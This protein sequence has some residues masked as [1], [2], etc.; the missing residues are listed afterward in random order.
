MSRQT[1]LLVLLLAVIIVSILAVAVSVWIRRSSGSYSPEITVSPDSGAPGVLITVRGEGWKPGEE[2]RIAV[3]TPHDVPSTD[4]VHTST[5]VDSQGRFS[6]YFVFQA[7]QRWSDLAQVWVIAQSSES[8]RQANAWFRLER[9]PVTP[10]P[11]LTASVLTTPSVVGPSTV[12]PVV[13]TTA[14]LSAVST[15]TPTRLVLTAVAQ[16]VDHPRGV[17]IVESQVPDIRQ[18]L[19]T[20]DTRFQYIDGTM[21]DLSQVRAQDRIELLGYRGADGE[22]VAE[23]ITLLREPP[24]F[25]TPSPEPTITV[26]PAP[27]TTQLPSNP[28]HGEYYAN[29]S[30]G[31][32]PSFVREES[33][34]NFDWGSGAPVAGFP[35]NH[36]SA[37]WTATWRLERGAYT[38]HVLADDGARLWVDGQLLIDQ[39]R[40]AAAAEHIAEI[41]LSEGLHSIRVE[42]FEA[43][44]DARIRVHWVLLSPYSG[45]KGEYYS[46]TALQGQPVLVRDDPRVEFDWGTGRPASGLGA[47]DF[48]VRWT[49]TYHVASGHYR[50]LATADDGLRLWVDDRLIIDEWHDAEQRTYFGDM[51]L[52]AGPHHFRI[53]YFEVMDH[54]R[55]SFW[56]EPIADFPDWRGEYF[57]N[58]VLSDL[59]YFVRNDQDIN[60]D[61]GDGSPGS[62]IPA[63]E[64]GVRWMRQVRFEQ[65]GYLLHLTSDDG[66]RLWL[67]GQLILDQWIDGLKT[68]LILSRDM[69]EGLHTV[70]LEYYERAGDARVHLWWE[71]TPATPTPQWPTT[72]PTTTP[73]RPTRT[74]TMT[75]ITPTQTHTTLPST[76]TPTSAPP[77]PTPTSPRP[78]RTPT[79]SPIPPTETPTQV[80]PTATV[81]PP[82]PTHTP[83]ATTLPPT[84]THT[85]VRPTSTV[86]PP[87]PTHTPT[88]T[89]V[90]PTATP[91]AMPP[92]STV[93]PPS[94]DTPT[95]TPAP[96]TETPTE[97]P[98]L[99]TSTPLPQT[100]TVGENGWVDALDASYFPLTQISSEEYD[101]TVVN[102]AGVVSEPR[103]WDWAPFF[104]FTV[105]ANDG[106]I[107]L[108]QGPPE[109]VLI[110]KTGLRPVIRSRQGGPQTRTETNTW[111]HISPVIYPSRPLVEGSTVI[112]VG[113][114][115]EGRIIAD[116]VDLI[117]GSQRRLWALRTL[118]T[119]GELHHR[120]TPLFANHWIWIRASADRVHRLTPDPVDSSLSFY[121]DQPVI[122]H[123]IL[124]SVGEGFVLEDVE[125]F[126]RHSGKYSRIYPGQSFDPLA[127]RKAS[128]T[129]VP[130]PDRMTYVSGQRLGGPRQ[131]A[132]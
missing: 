80:P 117:V 10:Q 22:L 94:T 29:R 35:T 11:P 42:Y 77:S 54:A 69:S 19:L 55:I 125:I 73:Q 82:P 53:E 124:Y 24:A 37:R 5:I 122:L 74:A 6:T 87:P 13:L 59:P 88:E 1:I 93:T 32:D 75:P 17:I 60:F 89:I 38:F 4:D 78:T 92:T 68:D 49:R 45:W 62:G 63:D 33:E 12:A 72:T 2:I 52:L 98:V 101:D 116:R 81:T 121:G 107:F 64:F 61:W 21:T 132:W 111:L 48:S 113:V 128:P 57:G 39:W 50:F 76:A 112:V 103:V 70:Q 23:R 83:T 9:E 105:T 51:T 25:P 56:T 44:G 30:L 99:P 119:E 102:L 46:G 15:A 96:P 126:A 47:D 97:T 31:G 79:A 67:D 108:V 114:R 65:G 14:T 86:T 127:V 95:V 27:T 85:P 66:A 115:Y 104:S 106:S 3:A 118:L 84:E 34:I 16:Q 8:T 100:P 131:E 18:V 130:M 40:E 41:S 43:E 90:P 91:T 109:G 28:W 7:D 129:D 110:Q 71:R 20:E 36:F 120:S 26:E 123:G 58:P